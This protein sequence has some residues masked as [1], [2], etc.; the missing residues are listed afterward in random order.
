MDAD[1]IIVWLLVLNLM[2]TIGIL[3]LEIGQRAQESV[4]KRYSLNEIASK[5]ISFYERVLKQWKEDRSNR[6]RVL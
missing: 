1:L 6:G 5:Q 2:A 3:A 4:E